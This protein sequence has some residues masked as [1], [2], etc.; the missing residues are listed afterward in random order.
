MAIVS[1]VKTMWL[2][3]LGILLRLKLNIMHLNQT[4]SG[5]HSLQNMVD[6]GLCNPCAG[7]LSST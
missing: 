7:A 4:F 6:Q 5:K 2:T 3:T 1:M